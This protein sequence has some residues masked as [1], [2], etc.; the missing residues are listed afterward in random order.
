MTFHTIYRSSISN[1]MDPDG[2][3]KIFTIL[4]IKLPHQNGMDNLQVK[5]DDSSEANILPL[6]SFMTMFPHALDEHGYPTEGFLE[7]SKI[8]LECYNKGRLINH[9]S[10]KLKLQHYSD[11]SFQDYYF[12]VIETKT[13]KEIITGHPVSVRLGLIHVLCKNVSKSISAIENR[14]TSSSSNSFQ[15]HLLNIDGK[16]WQKKQ[17]SKSES[18][19]DHSSD[20]F[21]TMAQ[22]A[23]SETPFETS[24]NNTGKS[25]PFRIINQKWQKWTNL[26]SFKTIGSQSE[27][28]A[29]SSKTMEDGSQKLTPFKTL[30]K[31]VKKLNPRYMV[32]VNEV[33]QVISNPQTAKTAQPMKDQPSSCPPWKGLRFNPIYLETG[34]TSIDS[35]RDVQA[36]LP[37]SFDHIGD[38]SGGYSIKTDPTVLPVQHARQKVLIEYKEEIKKELG[39]MVCQGIITKQTEPM[40]WVS[41]LTYHKKANG[42]LRICFNPKD[43]NE[44]IIPDHHN[45]PTLE[46]IAHVLRGAT[47]FS[48]VDGNKA[49]FGMHLTEVAS[50]L[51]TFTTHL[52]R[53]RF[54]HVPFGLKMNQD[55]F[56]MRMDDII[57]QCPGVLAIHDDVFIYGKDN[58]DHDANIINLFNIVQKEGLI[59][60][61]GKCSIKQDSMTFFGGVF[62]AKGYSPD[63]GKIQGIRDDTPSDEIG[64][65]IIFRGNKLSSNI[66]TPPHQSLHWTAMCTPEKGEQLHIG[67]ELKHKLP[68]NQIP[69]GESIAETPYRIKPVTLQ[70]DTSLKW[71][72]ACI[73]QDGHPI[74][75]TSKSLTDT[76]THYANMKE[77][78]PSHHVWLL[79]VPQLPV[80]KNIYSWNWPQTVGDDKYAKSHCSPSQATE[81]ASLTATVWNDHHIQTRQGNAPGWC[82]QPSPFKDRHTDPAQPQS[83]CHIDF[84]FHKELP[85][86]DCSRNT[87][88][89]CQQ[90]TDWCWMVCPTEAQMSPKLP[91][92][93]RISVINP[94]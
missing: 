92:T 15:D 33:S 41:S 60:K 56:Q 63:P 83:Q 40:P 51:M 86:Q 4:N 23:Q 19:Q 76:A 90:Y 31:R 44:A 54:L 17:R 91:E 68:E 24:H 5:V 35:T 72:R 81:N 64:A 66:H 74:A 73:I 10:I 85:D 29:G 27:K 34:S 13:P 71:L 62:S 93:T 1:E 57:A 45:A 52:G 2:K 67:W 9:G 58:K 7:R 59:L 21:K 8:N 50:L 14:E 61:S 18:F 3:T 55:I 37:N 48:K 43:L 69:T 77:G 47:K 89:S 75:F 80:W 88:R 20:S 36:L 38:M 28:M 87:K 6:D 78:T 12:Y 22:N 46:E 53:C 79:E 11:N 94:Q 32:L 84:S 65:T 25:L 42:K 70:C 39:E 16:P 82:P 26:A 30:A 49:F